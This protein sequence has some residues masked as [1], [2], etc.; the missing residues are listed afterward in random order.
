MKTL[1]VI[2][3]N[4]NVKYFVE[5]CLM[6]VERSIKNIDTE[7]FVVDNHSSDHSVSYLTK[8]FPHVRFINNQH[9]VGFS[10]ANNMAIRQSSGQYVLLLNPDTIVTEHTFTHA[11]NFMKE[12]PKAGGLGVCM[13]KSDGT[14]ALESRRG[15]PT[16][17]T[18]FYK[19]CGLC[20]K[21]PTHP[22]FGRYYLGHL[23]WHKPVQIEVI[24]GAFCMIRREAL[25]VVKGLDEDFFMYGEDIDLSYRILKAGFENWF[26]PT[27]I[28]HYKGESTQKSSFKYVHVFYNAM[29][30]FF[31]KHYGGM[32]KLLRLPIKM[33]IYL[34]ALTALTGT[35]FSF[36]QHNAGLSTMKRKENVYYVFI[37]ESE[38]LKECQEKAL[39]YGLEYEFLEG[40]EH[41]FING[42]TMLSLPKNKEVCVVYDTNAYS[43][44][45]ILTL[46]STKSQANVYIGTYNT[47]SK[48]IITPTEIYV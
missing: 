13:L 35:L 18:S 24:S 22:S 4:Y 9:N 12:H 34:K 15:L 30:I 47:Q 41:T 27:N 37:G 19:M 16:P 17:I 45:H 25:Q 29:L 48:V 2:I 46:F 42:H 10:R 20:A 1:S 7:I 28:L 21:F 5:Q 6:S 43:Y 44:H 39:K 38:M 8:R 33:A 3:V 26:L 36:L 14:P 31:K 11:I 40:T 23:P 32:S